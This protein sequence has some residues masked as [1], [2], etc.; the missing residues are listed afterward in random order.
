MYI[1]FNVPS[2]DAAIYFTR[3]S[4]VLRHNLCNSEGATE[5]LCKCMCDWNSAHYY[6]SANDP[7]D[8]IVL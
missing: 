2:Y 3:L 6:I 8:H 7:G 1:D 4:L 5:G